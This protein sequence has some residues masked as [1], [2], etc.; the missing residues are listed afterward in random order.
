MGSRP[1]LLGVA[2][3]GSG[4]GAAATDHCH[5]AADSELKTHLCAVLASSKLPELFF[6]VDFGCA[7]HPLWRLSLYGARCRATVLARGTSRDKERGE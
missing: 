7:F 6:E 4:D 3:R 5:S 2:Q 1:R